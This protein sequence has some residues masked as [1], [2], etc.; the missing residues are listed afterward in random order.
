[1]EWCYET[2]AVAKYLIALH[3][4]SIRL[5]FEIWMFMIKSVVFVTFAMT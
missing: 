4:A 1:M 3:I 5:G 2:S